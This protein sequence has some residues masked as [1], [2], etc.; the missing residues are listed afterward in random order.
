M[1]T[2]FDGPGNRGDFRPVIRARPAHRNSFFRR[3]PVVGILAAFIAIAGCQEMPVEPSAQAQ[4]RYSVTSGEADIEDSFTGDFRARYPF[5]VCTIGGPIVIEGSVDIEALAA[6]EA[7]MIGLIDKA[8]HELDPTATWGS[9]AYAYFGHIGANLRIGPSDGF[10][11]GELNQVGANIPFPALPTTIDFTLTIDPSTHKITVSYN[12]TDYVDDYGAIED[13]NVA[14]AYPGGEFDNGAILGVDIFDVTASVSYRLKLVSGCALLDTQAPEVTNVMADPN[15]VS[16]AQSFQLTANVDD[17][18]T[19]GSSIE[20]A[21][22]TLDGIAWVPMAAADGTFDEVVEDVSATVLHALSPGLYNVCVRGTDADG[23]TSAVE[24][25]TLVVYDPAGGFVT[26]GGWID[27]QAGAHKPIAPTLVWDQGFEVDVSGWSDANSGWFG[28]ITRVGSGTNGIASASGAWHALVTGDDV[29]APFSQFDAYRDT[30]TGSWTAEIDVYLDPDWADGEGFDYSVAATG[31]DGAHQRD[32]IFHVTKDIS[33][34]TLLVAGSNNTN[35]ALRQDLETINHFVVTTAGW[36]T[37][38]HV[39][40]DQAGA[41]AVDLNLLDAGGNVLFTETRFNAADLIPAEV[42]GNRYAWFTFA[43]VTNGLAVDNHELTFPVQSA[44]AGKAT[45]G[46]VAKYAKGASTPNGNTEFQ[47]KAAGLS[48]HSTSYDWLVV[49]QGGHNAQFKGW[50]EVNGVSGYRF[51]LWAGDGT[52][53]SGEDTFRIK[54]WQDGPS[55]EIVLYDN[56]MNQPI[57]AGNIIVHMGK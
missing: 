3:I 35:F 20:S 53:P 23:N 54:I 8:F 26:G 22:Y 43:D 30:W 55:G 42:G 38:Q 31:S 21:E 13:A 57:A 19:G 40:R 36:Y 48:L 7:V 6:G 9:G 16:V 56:G 52:G 50:A 49:N 28:Q 45:F 29:S 10:L 2:F 12:G 15:P 1:K 34:S 33:T 4:P 18:N 41:L 37:L 5:A 47:F 24:C 25:V 14:D 32:F 44:A 27:S 11:G 17:T 39:F 51:M 46:F